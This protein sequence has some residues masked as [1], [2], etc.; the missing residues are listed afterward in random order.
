M[1]DFCVRIGIRE[2]AEDEEE[3]FHGGSGR[4]CL[5]ASGERNPDGGNHPHAG[6]L[7]TEPLPRADSDDLRFPSISP[8]PILS[9]GTSMPR[10]HSSIPAI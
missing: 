10:G 2:G 9:A 1:L 4:L 3:S 7:V 8:Y 5:A 6:D